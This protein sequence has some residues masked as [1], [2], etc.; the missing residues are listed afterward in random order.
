[1]TM[2]HRERTETITEEDDGAGGR[3]DTHHNTGRAGITKAVKEITPESKDSTKLQVCSKLCK[4]EEEEDERKAA[5]LEENE[6]SGLLE[7][8]EATLDPRKIVEACKAKTDVGGEDASLQTRTYD[9]FMTYDKYYQ[10]P[11]LWLLAMTR[12]AAFNRGAHVTHAEVMK[13]INEIVAK[14]GCSYVSSNFLEMCTN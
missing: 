11:Q 5:N 3:V 8:D 4:E 7:T 9:L 12:T 2:G 13:K 6:E 1:M 14:G 10:A